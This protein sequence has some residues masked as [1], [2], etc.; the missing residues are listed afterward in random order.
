M[1]QQS[2]IHPDAGEWERELWWMVLA[3]AVVHVSLVLAVWLV[4]REMFLRPAPPVTSYVVDLVAP[5][6]IGGTNLIEGSKGRVQAAPMAAP[7]EPAPP[8]PK[9]VEPPP[10]PPVVAKAEPPAPPPPPA[11]EKSDPEAFAERQKPTTTRPVPTAT[12]PQRVAVAK[13]P[14]TKVP[15][16][17]VSKAALEAAA[18]KAAEEAKKKQM[19]EAAAKRKADEEA[20]LK[21]AIEAAGKKAAEEQ[22]RKAAQQAA[23]E[24][25][26]AAAKRAEQQI[27]E[28]GGGMGSKAGGAP[29]GPISVGPGE[30][31]GG[32]AVGVDYVLYLGQLE[33]RIKENW[34][35]A[36]EN[37]SLEAVVG[38]SIAESGDITNVRILRVSGDRGFDL[39]VERAVKAISPMPPPP[40]A[41]RTQFSDVEYTFNAKSLQQ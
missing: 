22:K 11:Q 7:P 37:D 28:R 12:Q 24:R 39:S 23:D 16:T 19:E 18:K 35:W 20:A 3:S 1:Q 15:P 32:Q 26:L 29:G 6:K 40:E 27:G 41:Y 2:P 30:G 14:P 10:E 31:A 21:K 36:G 17:V 8:P 38:F 34:A 4:P 5:D 33:R 9:A 25:I 13:P